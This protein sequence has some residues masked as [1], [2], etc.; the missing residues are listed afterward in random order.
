MITRSQ[1]KIEREAPGLKLLLDAI[2]MVEQTPHILKF[3]YD[4]SDWEMPPPP[5]PKRGHTQYYDHT[6]HKWVF[7]PTRN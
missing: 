5:A 1:T 2:D 3:N 7:V 4:T 6:Q